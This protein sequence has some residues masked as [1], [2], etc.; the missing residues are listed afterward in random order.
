MPTALPEG[1]YLHVQLSLG[2]LNTRQIL[3]KIHTFNSVNLCLFVGSYV[4]DGWPLTKLQT[5]LL[6]KYRIIPVVILELHISEREM[7]RRAQVNKDSC[8]R[9]IPM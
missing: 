1:E 9:Y 6:T 4:L 5:D 3:N 7:L 2:T 8:I